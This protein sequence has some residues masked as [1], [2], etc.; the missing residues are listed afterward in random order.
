M[1]TAPNVN[2]YSIPRGTVQF[3]PTGGSVTVL[4]NCPQFRYTADVTKLDHFSSQEGIRIKDRSVVTQLGATIAMVLDE[5]NEFNL[6]LF[7]L[8]E[9]GTSSLGGLTNTDLTGLLEFTGTNDIGSQVNFSGQ[10]SFLPGGDMDFIVENDWQTIPL[11]AEVLV[12]AGAYGEWTIEDQAT[13]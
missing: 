1:S 8:A 2:N 10:V 9:T 7:L 3:T 13:A 12:S 11:N 5:I 6:S 4:G